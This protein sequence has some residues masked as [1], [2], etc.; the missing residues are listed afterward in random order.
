MRKILRIV[1]RSLPDVKYVRSIA[2]RVLRPLHNRLVPGSDVVNV[3]GFHMELNP[4]ECVESAL[5]F[6]PDHYDRVE[7]QYVLD[8]VRAGIF[9][10]VGANVGF[11]S[12]FLANHFKG[13]TILAVE[14]NPR[15]LEVLK[16]NISI[17]GFDNVTSIG[18]GVGK[19]EG[20]F[21]LF[22]N[23]TGNRGGDTLSP[24]VGGGA[25]IE[26]PVRRLSDLLLERGIE[27]VEFMKIDIEG[28]ESLVF[29]D[30]RDNLPSAT[31]PTTICVETVF[32]PD[33]PT[34]LATMGYT[35]LASGRENSIYA[36][37]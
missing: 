31:W 33:L 3:L 5:W 25:S 11:W 27:R 23:E 29:E 28:M 13:S 34:I 9:L 1:G 22:L 21:P 19:E 35:K 26:V 18:C 10:D 16:K 2:T 15:T 12:L 30:L 14:A 20:A 8:N 37:N 4:A 32:C 17:N 7:R 6:T 36:R 24:A